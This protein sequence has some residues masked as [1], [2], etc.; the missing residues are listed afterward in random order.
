MSDPNGYVHFYLIQENNDLI[1]IARNSIKAMSLS[2]SDPNKKLQSGIGL[3]N[4][5][6]R[7]DLYYGNN[8]SFDVK[9]EN[10]SYIA[11]ITIG[12]KHNEEKV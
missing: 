4:V 1:F 11:K 7:L 12:G 8:Y 3:D 6:K 10:N 2:I 5:R 9:Q